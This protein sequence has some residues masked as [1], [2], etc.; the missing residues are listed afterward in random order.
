MLRFFIVSRLIVYQ[1]GYLD[2][3]VKMY[4]LSTRH[5]RYIY[6]FSSH[7]KTEM[8][9]NMCRV[10]VLFYNV[11]CVLERWDSKHREYKELCVL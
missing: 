9:K 3:D 8:L 1:S 4:K 10:D 7:K 2:L 6:P 11:N 5:A